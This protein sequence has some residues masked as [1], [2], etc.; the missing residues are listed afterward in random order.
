[1]AWL[2]YSGNLASLSVTVSPFD[3]YNY[4]SIMNS[5]LHFHISAKDLFDGKEHKAACPLATSQKNLPCQPI[6]GG[7]NNL[8]NTSSTLVKCDD[9]CYIY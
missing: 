8:K 1:M 4:L 9:K 5:S 7:G 2:N 3:K 6:Q